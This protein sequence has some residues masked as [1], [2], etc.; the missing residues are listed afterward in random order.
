MDNEFALPHDKPLTLGAFLA[1]PCPEAF[2]EPTAVHLPLTDMPL[3]LTQEI[4]VQVPLEATYQAAFDGLAS[5][6]RNVLTDV[7]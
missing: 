4:Y 1:G 6:W 3:F 2:I 5:V 7:S